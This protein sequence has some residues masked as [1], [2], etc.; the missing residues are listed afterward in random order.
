M[1]YLSNNHIDTHTVKENYN[2]IKTNC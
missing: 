1:N 2:T